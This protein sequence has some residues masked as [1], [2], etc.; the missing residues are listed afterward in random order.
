MYKTVKI[1]YKFSQ[2]LNIR[3]S[4]SVHEC[5]KVGVSISD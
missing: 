1:K 2:D 4:N 3:Y 5:S